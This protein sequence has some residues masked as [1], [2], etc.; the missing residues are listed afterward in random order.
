MNQNSPESS[1]FKLSGCFLLLPVGCGIVFVVV[2]VFIVGLIIP[3]LPGWAQSG[4][5]AWMLDKP[6]DTGSFPKPDG[7]SGGGKIP[8][9]GGGGGGGHPWP[10]DHG[11]VPGWSK[12][13]YFGRTYF[14][15]LSSLPGWWH[16]FQGHPFDDQM[17]LAIIF[18][19]ELAS[20]HGDPVAR[21]LMA[22]AMA[23]RCW[24]SIKLY[25]PDGCLWYLGGREMVI[26]R[27]EAWIAG[28]N[29][30]DYDMMQAYLMAWEMLNNPDW[31]KGAEW[32][33]PYEWGNPTFTA[34]LIRKKIPAF[35]KA[36]QNHNVGT[37][38]NQILYI[39][40][41]GNFF[42]VTQQQQFNL[43]KNHSCVSP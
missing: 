13:L 29:E 19:Y 26:R 17:Y 34:D 35:W 6:Q 8:D 42:I 31:Q 2:F 10:D 36:L 40:P 1:F 16:N 9:G 4:V 18:N 32:N 38:P 7:G 21:Q 22:E 5:R 30:G 15:I 43:C 25:G 24:E 14:D 12:F 41:D 39:S 27:V 3:Q 11:P 33:K 20:F 28:I 37:G 23:R